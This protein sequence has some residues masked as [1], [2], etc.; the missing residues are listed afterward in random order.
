MLFLQLKRS[1][2]LDDSQQNRRLTCCLQ[3]KNN[4][5][6]TK[7]IFNALSIHLPQQ[8]Q[9]VNCINSQT[10]FCVT[11]I[12]TVCIHQISLKSIIYGTVQL[13]WA[14]AQDIDNQL[15][16]S[17]LLCPLTRISSTRDIALLYSNTLKINFSSRNSTN[18]S[19]KPT[20]MD[21]KTLK[22]PNQSLICSP[23]SFRNQKQIS[24]K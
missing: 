10:Q 5:F 8:L 23:F 20:N 14:P 17:H 7:A 13:I 18:L 4:S 11:F 2:I 15:K 12:P 16:P 24:F 1:I 21:L 22:G 9:F 3:S 6:N 19:T